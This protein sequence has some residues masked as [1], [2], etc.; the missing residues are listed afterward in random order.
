MA[1]TIYDVAKAAGVGVG[2]VSRVLNNSQA[3]KDSTREKVLSAIAQL[4]YAPDP[5]AR[6][7]ITGRTRVLGVIIPFVT[8]AFS[9]EVLR[10][11]VKAASR[12]NYE[13]VIYN[14]EDND[15]RDEYFTQVPMRRRVD[16]LIIVSLSPDE[17][18]ASNFLKA[19]L[20][21]VLVDAYSPFFTS[22]VVNNMEGAYLAVK[23]L[24]AKGHHRVGFINGI[25]EGNFK[26]NQANDR[27]IGVH[28]AFSEAGIVYDPQL[29]VT[30]EWNRAGGRSAA[31]QLL[32]RPDPPT[33]IFASSDVQAVGV[34]EAARG[35]NL[36]VP[37]DLSVMGFD[38]IELSE[39][40]ELST[41]QQPMQQMG[42][43]GVAK[44]M[45]LIENAKRPPELVRLDSW[46]VERRTTSAA[47]L[48]L[49]LI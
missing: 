3:V 45:D 35:L 29:M 38:G 23:S 28:R 26:F 24:I 39:I 17:A 41:V 15:Q 14:V 10:G 49:E 2:T 47:R 4:N 42:E 27:L 6:S 33:A 9:V 34:L 11:V 40:L 5:I 22:L 20:P 21:T 16:G 36:H 8:R 30:T 37:D 46:L 1:V 44:V 13:L 7:M 18:A 12:F 32:H 25:I 43:L 19:G 48:H 31:E